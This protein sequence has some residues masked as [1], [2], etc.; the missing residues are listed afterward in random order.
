[1]LKL[2]L[3][4]LLLASQTAAPSPVVDFKVSPKWFYS[5]NGGKVGEVNYLIRLDKP[6][7]V[8]CTGWVYPVVQWHQEDWPLRRSCR[9]SDFKSVSESWGGKKY[10]LPLI[11]EYIAFVEVYEYGKL[12]QLKT[13]PFKQLE[14]IPK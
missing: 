6:G 5:Y 8:I 1:M 3:F 11:G 14:G 7:R 12:V 10:P 9:V 2:I 4:T 13:Q